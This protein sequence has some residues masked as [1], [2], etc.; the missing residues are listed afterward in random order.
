VGEP[1]VLLYAHS[2]ERIVLLGPM[3]ERQ[4]VFQMQEQRLQSRSV[5][6]R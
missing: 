2:V 3:H 6:C 1:Y 5:P 4:L